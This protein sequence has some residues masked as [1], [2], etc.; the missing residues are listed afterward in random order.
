MSE[1]YRLVRPL[2]SNLGRK[3]Y[4]HMPR[5]IFRDNKLAFNAIS[6]GECNS[7]RVPSLKRSNK[8]WRNF[9]NLFP[10]LKGEKTYNGLKLK[11]VKNL[12]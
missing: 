1:L 7:V 12:W 4:S 10:W 5:Q 6:G 8:T 2:S 9:Y 3:R 11:S